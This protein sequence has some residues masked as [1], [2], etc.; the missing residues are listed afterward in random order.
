MKISGRAVDKTGVGCIKVVADDY[1]RSILLITLPEPMAAVPLF[2][3]EV[4]FAQFSSGAP[5]DAPPAAASP[6]FVEPS[7]LIQGG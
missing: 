7:T 3:V 5:L 1:L 2:E 4:V 6:C